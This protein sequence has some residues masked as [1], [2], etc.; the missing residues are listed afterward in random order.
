MR[1]RG[2]ALGY[3]RAR[4]PIASIAI[5]AVSQ[6]R[7]ML[8]RVPDSV[9]SNGLISSP[10]SRSS[11]GVARQSIGHALGMGLGSTIHVGASAVRRIDWP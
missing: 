6:T 3:A 8:L 10:S 1:G 9:R 5:R 11:A 2:A 4:C 7:Y